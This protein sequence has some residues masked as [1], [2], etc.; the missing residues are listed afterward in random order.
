MNLANRR[1]R[2]YACRSGNVT[3]AQKQAFD[4]YAETWVLPYAN[5]LLNFPE[6]FADHRPVTLEIGFGSG[7]ATMQIARA[8]PERGYLGVEVYASGVGKLLMHI[9][10]QGLSNLRIIQHDVVEVLE[11]MIPEA[12]L[13]AV[14]VFFPD[15]WP[16]KRHHKRRLLQPVFVHYLAQRMK[17]GAYFYF[18]TDWREYADQVLATCQEEPLF[19][20]AYQDFSP[21]QEWRPATRFEKKGCEAERDILEVYMLRK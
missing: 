14:H 20:N 16:K 15:P 18:V 9:E 4:S 19:A 7:D 10:E 21:A 13:D 17:S 11:N 5:R 8:H 1:I 6:I 3:K 2:S 12:S